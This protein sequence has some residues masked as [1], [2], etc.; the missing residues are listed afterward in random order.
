VLE[1]MLGDHELPSLADVPPPA[2]GSLASSL[3][4]E[5]L[6]ALQALCVHTPSYGTRSATILGLAPGRVLHYRF[7]DGPPCTTPFEDVVFPR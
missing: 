7:A 3:S 5:Q 2:P 6:R 1:S 4:H